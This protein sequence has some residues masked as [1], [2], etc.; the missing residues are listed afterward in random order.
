MML[1]LVLTVNCQSNKIKH[2]PITYVTE[3]RDTLYVMSD[4]YR[5]F[6]EIWNKPIN[7]KNK[8]IIISVSSLAPYY[9]RKKKIK[10][11]KK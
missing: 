10:K 6:E 2:S 11:T 4:I 1:T 8:P 7:V 3:S 9:E 5:L